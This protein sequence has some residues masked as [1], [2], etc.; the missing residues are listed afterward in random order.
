MAAENGGEGED[1][2]DIDMMDAEAATRDAM[3]GFKNE[4]EEWDG[5]EEM[6]KR[7]IREY[8][9]EVYGMEFN[10][11]VRTR[12]LLSLSLCVS[13]DSNWTFFPFCYS[14]GQLRSAVISL[15]DLNTLLSKKHRST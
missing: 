10:D 15:H 6:R 2:V 11:I 5:T 1:G 7:K 8:M 4:E 13:P 14:P 9:D 12:S 3:G